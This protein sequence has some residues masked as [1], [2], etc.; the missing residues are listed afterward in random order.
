MIDESTK[1][2]TQWQTLLTHCHGEEVVADAGF[3][4]NLLGEL[5]AKTQQHL[6]AQTAADEADADKWSTLIQTAYI[7]CHPEVHFKNSLLAEL[8]AR[9]TSIAPQVETA[10]ATTAAAPGTEDAAI[11]TL[12]TRSYQPVSARKEFETR[13]LDNLK[14]RQRRSSSNRLRARRRTI[15]LSAASSIAAAAMVMFVVWVMPVSSMPASGQPSPVRGNLRLPV[16]DSAIVA[17]RSD[18]AVP[19]QFVSSESAVAAVPAVYE[20]TVPASFSFANYKV[21]DAFQGNALPERAVSLQNLEVDRG[22]GWVTLAPAAAIALAPGMRFRANGGMGHLEFGDGSMISL[23]PNSLLEATDKGL[24]VA[25][26]FMLV[27]VPTESEQRFRLHFPERDI[28]VEPGTDLAVLV[29]PQANYAAGGAPAPMVMVVDRQDAPGGM[30]LAK[31]KNGVGPL[32]AKQIYRLDNYVTPALPGRTLC[33]TEC[34]DLEKFY[35]AET[36]VFQNPP[37]SLVGGF[38]GH[39]RDMSYAATV[40][41]PAGF[42]KKGDKWVADS[43][44]GQP[45]VRIKYLS[46][47]YFGFAN[48]RRDLAR[49]LSLGGEVVIDGGDGN[50]YEIY[51]K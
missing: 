28:A 3:K 10:A 40:L 48:E 18:A 34:Q 22:R 20:E 38:A 44:S 41:T 49:A 33:D 31:G 51:E 19:V 12:L 50:F 29:E 17:N 35:K 39:D 23:S 45:T 15:F 26:G 47:A 30:A 43:F 2:D 24:S 14:E 32:L 1:W 37:A 36:V 7:P 6:E 16:P 8:K 4:S 27:A 25:E 11:R 5:K 9:Q 42:A 46:D 21:E 13:L